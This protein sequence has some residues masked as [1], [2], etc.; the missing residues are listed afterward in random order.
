MLGGSSYPVPTVNTLKISSILSRLARPEDTMITPWNCEDVAY[1][2]E[3]LCK[4]FASTR[5]IWKFAI[6][7]LI[8]SLTT[9]YLTTETGSCITFVRLIDDVIMDA[10]D[11]SD[12]CL[13]FLAVL[14]FVIPCSVCYIMQNDDTYSHC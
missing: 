4:L 11:L 7:W 10:G 3:L 14:T 5:S 6:M 8:S 1:D 12:V 13:P 2:E 9:A